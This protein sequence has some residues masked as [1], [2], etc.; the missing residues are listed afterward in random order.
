MVHTYAKIKTP[1]TAT[2]IYLAHNIKKQEQKKPARTDAVGAQTLYRHGQVP[3]S[4]ISSSRQSKTERA[5]PTRPLG[6]ADWVGRRGNRS[7]GDIGRRHLLRH[8]HKHQAGI[9]RRR[10]QSPRVPSIRGARTTATAAVVARMS[11]WRCRIFFRLDRYRRRRRSSSS[12]GTRGA[13][14]C[15]HG[16]R[17]RGGNPLFR[18]GVAAGPAVQQRGRQH[19]RGGGPQVVVVSPPSVRRGR[20]AIH[21]RRAARSCDARRREVAGGGGSTT[22]TGNASRAHTRAGRGSGGDERGREGRERELYPVGR[23]RR[24]QLP[25]RY[26]P[27]RPAHFRP[28]VLRFGGCA[29]S[30]G[31]W[32]RRFSR[33]RR[34][35][36]G[37]RCSSFFSVRRP[38]GHLGRLR[39]ARRCGGRRSTAR[40]RLRRRR[41]RR[42][43]SKFQG[44]RGPD[45]A[46][47][48]GDLRERGGQRRRGLRH[49]ADPA[50]RERQTRGV[51]LRGERALPAVQQ[52]QHHGHVV[53]PGVARALGVRG[54]AGIQQ[55][56]AHLSGRGPR[57]EA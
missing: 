44:E 2:C 3:R 38:A 1:E 27:L 6:G 45:V 49:A 7:N 42:R 9:I 20:G 57:A 56:L 43:R 28:V 52:H 30:L 5:R 4:V 33:C 47:R 25:R 48:P 14:L 29:L 24:R 32:C 35:C 36:Y 39:A 54:Q 8:G 55:V 19:R 53:A 12:N 16:D 13:D 11:I 37:G 34:R 31:S 40:Q 22:A 21:L 50:P 18:R 10:C 51:R 46:Q 41:R 15:H 26:S 17:R 23:S